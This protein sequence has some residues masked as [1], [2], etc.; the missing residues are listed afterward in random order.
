M[1]RPRYTVEQRAEALALYR[2][3]GPREAARRVGCKPSTIVGWAKDAGVRTFGSTQTAAATEK[4]KVTMEA[5]RAKLAERLL[6]VAANLVERIDSTRT[7]AGDARALAI[8][9]GIFVDKSQ[10]LSGAA[11]SRPE[12]VEPAERARRLAEVRDELASRRGDRESLEE[13]LG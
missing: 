11:T 1:T 3:H 13:R 12:T 10:L 2:D 5:R 9:V 6:E 7:A 4:I 8:P